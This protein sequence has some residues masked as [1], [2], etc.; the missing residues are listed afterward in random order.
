M[1]KDNMIFFHVILFII[2]LA[3]NISCD[4][5]DLAEFKQEMEEQ[6]KNLKQTNFLL[7]ENVNFLKRTVTENQVKIQVLKDENEELKSQ[8]NATKVGIKDLNQAKGLIEDEVTTMNSQ[9]KTLELITVSESCLEISNHGVTESKIYDLDFDGISRGQLPIKGHCELPSGFTTIGETL[10]IDINQCSSPN[11][12]VFDVEYTS[13]MRDQMAALIKSSTSCH[14][15]IEFRCL[16][17]PLVTAVS[18]FINHLILIILKFLDF[19]CKF[20][21]E[22][23]L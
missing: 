14:Q 5:I 16:S 6:I 12:F 1:K 13:V 20:C 3:K 4:E 10:V 18:V 17:A 19:V 23:K 22:Q 9:I 7:Q 21:C 15:N 2:F 8:L 11:C